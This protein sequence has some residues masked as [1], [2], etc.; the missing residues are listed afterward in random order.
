MKGTGREIQRLQHNIVDL[1]PG[2]PSSSRQMKALR[3]M[4]VNTHTHTHTHTHHCTKFSFLISVSL[5]SLHK[6]FSLKDFFS[7]FDQIQKKLR[8]SLHLLK[9]HLMKNFIFVQCLDFVILIFKES[10]L[11]L[12]LSFLSVIISD[13][14]NISFNRDCDRGCLVSLLF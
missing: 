6:R 10:S 1:F 11:C 5:P 14:P 7:K 3:W 12:F 2:S 8:I 4:D 13:S 9:K